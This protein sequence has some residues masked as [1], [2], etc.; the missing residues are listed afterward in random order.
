MFKNQQKII[1][2][3]WFLG[4]NNSWIAKIKVEVKKLNW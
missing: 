4:T 2:S 3:S 1:T